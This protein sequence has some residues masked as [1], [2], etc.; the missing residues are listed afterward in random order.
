MRAREVN[1]RRRSREGDEPSAKE[2]RKGRLPKLLV[3]VTGKGDLREQS[4]RE[5]IDLEEREGWEWVRCRSVWM[6]A[7]DYPTLLG[8]CSTS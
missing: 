1:S 8:M 7:A 3:L 5:M 4:M 2:K 6:S